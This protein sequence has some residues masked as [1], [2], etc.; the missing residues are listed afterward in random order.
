M[1]DRPRP[2]LIRD[3]TILKLAHHGSRNGT[4]ARVAGPGPARARRRQP[5]QGQRV[6]PPPLRDDRLLR[7]NEIPLLRT[8]QRGTITIVSDG[9][10]LE[11]GQPQIARRQGS[12][13]AETVASSSDGQETPARAS[14]SGTRRK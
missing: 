14:Q 12:D 7:R 10:H 2:R 1:V 5:G 4:D 13:D 3:C 11:P 8:D 9:R 6:R